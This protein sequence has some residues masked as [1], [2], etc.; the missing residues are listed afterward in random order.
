[1]APQAMVMKRK[2]KTFPGIMGPPPWTNGR[3]LEVGVD[4]EDSD[5]ESEDRD[6]LE[7]GAEIVPRAEQQPHGQHGGDEPVGREGQD[8]ALPG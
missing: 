4:H 8:D 6:D 1:M 2:G 7:V 5:D 3:H